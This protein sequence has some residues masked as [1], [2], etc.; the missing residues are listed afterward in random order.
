MARKKF[1]NAL[2]IGRFQPLHDG[3]MEVIRDAAG[4]SDKLTIIIAG[5]GKPD[6][7]NPFSFSERKR[8][9]KLA[10]SSAKIKNYV[11]RELRDVNAD[12]RWSAAIARLGRFDIAYSRNP[13]T[14]RCLKAAGIPV[15][16]HKFYAR[17]KNCG[18]AIRERIMHRKS[19]STLVPPAVYKYVQKINGEKRIRG[20]LPEK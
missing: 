8:M 11:V 20:S 19:W 9:I 16:K 12:K 6:A 14:S 1:V 2:F 18:R 5:P 7:R 15:A 17:Y 4:S 3:H 13:W 10:L